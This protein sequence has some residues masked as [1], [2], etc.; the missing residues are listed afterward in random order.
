MVLVTINGGIGKYKNANWSAG[1][2][3]GWPKPIPGLHDCTGVIASGG[4]G[5]EQS[6]AA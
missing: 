2:M 4:G 6:T 5:G 1:V 3:A